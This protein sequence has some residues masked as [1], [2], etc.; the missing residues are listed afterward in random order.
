[1]VTSIS[2]ESMPLLAYE[3]PLSV[4]ILPLFRLRS[5][6]AEPATWGAVK[7]GAVVGVPVGPP[8]AGERSWSLCAC[9][10]GVWQRTRVQLQICGL[11]CSVEEHGRRQP[12]SGPALRREDQTRTGTPSGG[13]RIRT[14]LACAQSSEE[15]IIGTRIQTAAEDRR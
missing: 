15:G 6:R 7:A 3:K 8:G 14:S 12:H 9:W 13:T 11:T 2:A 4:N 1:M 5:D 10:R